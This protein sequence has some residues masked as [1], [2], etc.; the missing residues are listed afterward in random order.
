MEKRNVKNIYPG[1]SKIS[2]ANNINGGGGK[3]S[4]KKI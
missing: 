4:F 1:K 2:K 3:G